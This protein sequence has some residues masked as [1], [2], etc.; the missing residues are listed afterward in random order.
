MARRTNN[1]IRTKHLILCE[2][3]DAEELL[4][5]YLNSKDLSDVP[6]FSNDFQVMYFCSGQAKL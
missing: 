6:A 5:T 2:G 1:R 3:R 4:I